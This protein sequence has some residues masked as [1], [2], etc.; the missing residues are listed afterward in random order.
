MVV[1]VNI[2]LGCNTLVYYGEE[3]VTTVNS[4]IVKASTFFQL[5]KSKKKTFVNVKF[6]KKL[7]L[8]FG[9]A[10]SSRNRQLK[11]KKKLSTYLFIRLHINKIFIGVILAKG[12]TQEILY[13]GRLR[14]RP[15]TVD[16]LIMTTDGSHRASYIIFHKECFS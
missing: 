10:P 3:L 6:D 9:V 2:R 15:S 4:C 13:Q 1:D 14:D 16:L 11:G 5:A 8:Q 7:S 12:N